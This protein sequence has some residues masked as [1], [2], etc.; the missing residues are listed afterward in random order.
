MAAGLPDDLVLEYD[1]LQLVDGEEGTA[2]GVSGGSGFLSA[3]SCPN[4][5]NV[6]DLLGNC[7]VGVDIA[8][9]SSGQAQCPDGLS[10]ED[11]ELLSALNGG[12]DR[13]QEAHEPP[14]DDVSA[15]I[16]DGEAFL[17]EMEKVVKLDGDGKELAGKPCACYCPEGRCV[18]GAVDLDAFT[19]VD[20]LSSPCPS[21]TCPNSSET[22]SPCKSDLG[23][24]EIDCPIL[25][26]RQA[27]AAWVAAAQAAHPSGYPPMSPPAHPALLTHQSSSNLSTA[28]TVTATSTHSAAGS[29]IDLT[30]DDSGADSEDMDAGNDDF[31]AQDKLMQLDSVDEERDDEEM[32]EEEAQHDIDL[33][34]KEATYLVAQH[35]YL[36]S[37][38][39]SSR[40]QRASIKSKRRGREPAAVAESKK[41]LADSAQEKN[42]LSEMVSQQMAY[43]DNFKAMLSFAPVNDVVCGLLI[44][45]SRLVASKGVDNVILLYSEWRS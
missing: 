34:E 10:K 3:P 38:A 43:V 23:D 26:D 11:C 7:S 15:F 2:G 6:D 27:H 1:L 44:Y 22:A 24:I 41:K 37:R 20:V 31:D 36:L 14:D 30:T 12:E 9:D 45:Y 8:A 32:T 33:L 18:C 21:S 40:P 42:M 29:P 25:K 35:D 17:R 16:V 28:S 5:F 4:A 39:K 19:D 13:R